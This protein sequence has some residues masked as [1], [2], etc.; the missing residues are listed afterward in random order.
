MTRPNS[1]LLR[2]TLDMLVLQVLSE[3]PNH[4]YAI[5]QQIQHLTDDRLRIEQILQIGFRSDDRVDPAARVF[6]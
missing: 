2:G 3:A 6:R 4:G 5:G 1:D